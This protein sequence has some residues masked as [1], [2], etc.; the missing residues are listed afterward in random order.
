MIKLYESGDEMTVTFD[1][2]GN[3]TFRVNPDENVCI[4]MIQQRKR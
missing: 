2:D 3:D 4:S 1:N